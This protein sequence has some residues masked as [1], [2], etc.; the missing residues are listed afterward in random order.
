MK[1]II[2]NDIVRRAVK[3]FIQ[4]FIASLMVSI[5]NNT[6]IDEKMIK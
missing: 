6:G 2:K 5:N 1:K 3:T 4:G